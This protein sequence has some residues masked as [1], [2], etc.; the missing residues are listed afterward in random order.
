MRRGEGV[1]EKSV[2]G[3]QI[4]KLR[5]YILEHSLTG[6]KK[7]RISNIKYLSIQI[8]LLSCCQ[9][10]TETLTIVSILPLN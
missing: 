3:D 8:I 7:K 4:F 6:F 10:C 5:T 2:K 9:F 1:G